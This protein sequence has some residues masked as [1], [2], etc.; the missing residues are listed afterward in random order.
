MLVCIFRLGKMV[1]KEKILNTAIPRYFK[2]KLVEPQEQI[3]QQPITKDDEVW[4]GKS[5]K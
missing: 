3:N 4:N 5:C 2:K 1:D